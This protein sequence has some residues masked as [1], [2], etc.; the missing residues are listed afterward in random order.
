VRQCVF[1]LLQKD[2]PTLPFVCEGKEGTARGAYRLA[3]KVNH[4]ERKEFA[5]CFEP[6]GGR[7]CQYAER[8]W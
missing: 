5:V 8:S 6:A 7:I 2:L 1:V 3:Q 4:Q